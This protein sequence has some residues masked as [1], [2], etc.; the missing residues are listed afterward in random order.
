MGNL[1]NFS[2]N[3]KNFQYILQKSNTFPLKSLWT[4]L[5]ILNRNPIV[6]DPTIYF[7]PYTDT[8]M[9]LLKDIPPNFR[10]KTTE[11]SYIYQLFL[12]MEVYARYFGGNINREYSPFELKGVFRDVLFA[13]NKSKQNGIFT[14]LLQTYRHLEYIQEIHWDIDFFSFHKGY[15]ERATNAAQFLITPGISTLPCNMDV[16]NPE[17][18]PQYQKVI[19]W[20][21][22]N[23]LNTHPKLYLDEKDFRKQVYKKNLQLYYVDTHKKKPDY[24][25]TILTRMVSL[26]SGIED[27]KNLDLL[28]TVEKYS[29]F[30]DFMADI[31]LDQEI[32]VSS[33]P[34][35]TE[36]SDFED[37][38]F[39][40]QH[41]DH[42]NM[43]TK[44]FLELR[45]SNELT[46]KLL[47]EMQN[48]LK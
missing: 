23:L 48:K 15:T 11:D 29:F 31:L 12:W 35:K 7:L 37:L 13:F 1:F 38:P 16:F 40:N 44:I 43:L 45:K 21:E 26:I 4:P 46:E 36:S 30:N 22:A 42:N 3:T 19:T 10:L 2:L 27:N 14:K 18:I 25:N 9:D 20:V 34:T 28:K 24:Y 8:E 6:K 33:A 17:D 32:S 5:H 39:L 47:I 41:Q